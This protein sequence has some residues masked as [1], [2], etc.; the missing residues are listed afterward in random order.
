MDKKRLD[1]IK[2]IKLKST[3]KGKDFAKLTNKEKDELLGTV[4]KMLGIL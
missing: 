1:E 2:N 3:K 4:C